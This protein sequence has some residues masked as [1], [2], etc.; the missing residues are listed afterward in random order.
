MKIVKLTESDLRKIV[1]KVL[2]EQSNNLE[3]VDAIETLGF[4]K[5]SC[6]NKKTDF[7][8]EWCHN[9]KPHIVIQYKDGYLQLLNLKT[10]EK[11]PDKVFEVFT[12]DDLP[13]LEQSI[14]SMM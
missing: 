5:K 8:F 14:K 1:K 10:Y 12:L 11:W 9:K 2:K 13:D 3:I 4:Q 7:G 6:L